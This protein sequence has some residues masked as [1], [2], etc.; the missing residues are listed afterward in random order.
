MGQK[1]EFDEARQLE[2]NLLVK[3]ADFCEK[4][5][6]RYYLA[7]GT[8]IGAVRHKGFIPWDNDVDVVMP[9]PDYTRF[10]ELIL[11][12]PIEDYIEV[13]DYHKV[14]TFPFIKLIDN[15][16]RLKEH[17]LVTEDNLGIYIDIFPLDGF[18]DSKEEQHR[19]F[20]KAAFYY[21]LYA[22]A[23][24]RFNTGANFWK[25]LIKNTLYP[26][27]RL[28]SSYKVCELLNNLCK[29]YDY[30]QSNMVGDIVWG[31]DEREIISKEC[32]QT[33]YGE[34]EEYKLRIPQGFDQYLTQCYG[35]YMRLPKEEERIIH[36]FDAEWKNEKENI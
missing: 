36:Q 29:A 16:T 17:F 27:S 10:M 28:V 31:F 11:R 25:K 7:Y 34:F 23:N 32:F 20:K 6:L 1:I 33:I 4:E 5:N 15:R 9:R 8:L 14:K 13:L 3:F 18:P 35:E 26:F 30:D 12:R 19:L 24:Y 22:F 21:K 2:L